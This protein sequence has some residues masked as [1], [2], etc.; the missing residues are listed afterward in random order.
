M[1]FATLNQLSRKL[2]PS[3]RILIW[4]P[5]VFTIIFLG[6]VFMTWAIADFLNDKKV[7]EKFSAIWYYAG[8]EET[9]MYYCSECGFKTDIKTCI[10]PQCKTTMRN[11][12]TLIP[13]SGFECKSISMDELSYTYEKGIR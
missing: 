13:L 3:W 10:C 9:D 11:G 7:S 2:M 5:V 6:L 8:F 4:R 12:E 1:Y